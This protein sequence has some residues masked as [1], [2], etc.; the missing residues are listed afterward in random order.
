M[1]ENLFKYR[2]VIDQFA[3]FR[4]LMR[5]NNLKEKSNSQKI[6]RMRNLNHFLLLLDE[7][8]ILYI[9]ENDLARMYASHM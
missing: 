2:F 7:D 8:K 9:F 4:S 6:K 1:V 5:I 3:S